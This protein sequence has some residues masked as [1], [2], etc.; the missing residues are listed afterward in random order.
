LAIK[1]SICSERL[2]NFCD[3]IDGLPLTV[4]LSSEQLVLVDCNLLVR[5]M[6]GDEIVLKIKLLFLYYNF[7]KLFHD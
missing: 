6:F 2:N 1:E 4:H 5:P 7:F 3:V